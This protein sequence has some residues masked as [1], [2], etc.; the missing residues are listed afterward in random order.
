MRVLVIT[1]YFWPEYFRINDIVKYL[2][3]K[4]YNVDVLTSVPNYPSGTIFKDFKLNKVNYSHYYGAKIYR[5]P[6]YLRRNSNKINLF[7]NYIS[8]VISTCVIGFFITRKKKY[9]IIFFFGTSP[10]T[11][12]IPGLFFS[13]IKK[14]YSVLW[15]L[16]LWPNI[17]LELKIIKNLYIYRILQKIVNFI[18][19]NYYIILAQSESFKSELLKFNKNVLVFYSWA[20][21][22]DNKI[23]NKDFNKKIFI[24]YK[25]DPSLKIVFTGN[26]GEAQNFKNILIC[27]DLLKE[28]HN[29]KWIIVGTGRVLNIMKK[30]C[31]EKKIQNIIFEGQQESHTIPLYHQIA[32]ILLISLV[33]GKG[34]SATIPGKLQTYL[35]ANKY[36][37]GFIDGESKRIIYESKTGSV[38][39][40]DDPQEL[41][42]KIIF[43]NENRNI[44]K[45][46]EDQSRG[47]KYLKLN[48]DKYKILY[49]L[50]II[51]NNIYN[52][53]PRFNLITKPNYISFRK[54]FSLSGL[55]LAFLGYLGSKKITLEKHIILWPDGIFYKRFFSSGVKKMSGRKLLNNL[56]LPSYIKNIYI[57]G[58]LSS[59]GKNYLNERFNKNVIHISLPYGSIE[60]IYQSF[61]CNFNAEDIII[62]T[63]PTPLQE[64]L[65]NLIAKNNNHFKIFCIGGALSM[66]CGDEI[67]VPKY[68]DNLGLEFLWRL[69]VETIRRTKR[70]FITFFYYVLT[71][72]KFGYSSIRSVII[73]EN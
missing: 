5:V 18:Y 19:K 37:L 13:K 21:D 14:C 73:E 63:L 23:D 31:Y 51:F 45:Q 41:C 22:F 46:V 43:L 4:K 36:I 26:I 33:S 34:L 25:N 30:I 54:N 61:K 57:L 32:D 8:Y 28:N 67:S 17:L 66:A 38:V 48:Y 53:Y 2:K 55:N 72:F 56:K 64:L 62:I 7:I 3:K 52:L 44:L 29:I 40:P 10:I 59:R 70:L 68:L 11:S 6:I 27:A 1:Q 69:R 42:N 65:A 12:A 24:K 16:D 9:Y 20:E 60:T 39:S 15:V 35:K 71:E 58:N 50:E 49:N 47:E